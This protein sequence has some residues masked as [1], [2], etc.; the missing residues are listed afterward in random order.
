MRLDLRNFAKFAALGVTGYMGGQIRADQERQQEQEQQFNRALQMFQLQRGMEDDDARRADQADQ[1]LLSIL[2]NVHPSAQGAVMERV[3]GGRAA[4]AGAPRTGLDSVLP[5]VPRGKEYDG[6]RDYFGKIAGRNAAP[7]APT[8]TGQMLNGAAA[9]GGRSVN[10]PGFGALPLRDPA[11]E[12]AYG[13]AIQ[14]YEG[15]LD[16]NAKTPIRD[17]AQRQKLEAALGQLRGGSAQ[18]APLEG[19]GYGPAGLSLLAPPGVNPKDSE[20]SMKAIEETLAA[21]DRVARDLPNDEWGTKTRQTIATL[22]GNAPRTLPQSPDEL[23]ASDRWRD[24]AGLYTLNPS[25]GRE[26]LEER[27]L[28]DDSVGY[29]DRIN[30]LDTL[31]DENLGVELSELIGMEDGLRKRYGARKALA[32]RLGTHRED[33]A[34]IKAALD[35]GDKATA[36][37]LAGTLRGRITRRFTPAQERTKLSEVMQ[38][39][40]RMSDTARTPENMR[41]LFKNAGV[42]Y[43]V[44]DLPDGALSFGGQAAD[45]AYQQMIGK[46]PGFAKLDKSSQGLLLDEIAGLAKATGRQVEIP[47]AIVNNDPVAAKRLALLDKQITLAGDRIERD[48]ARWNLDKQIRQKELDNLKAGGTKSGKG[49]AGVEK[50]GPQQTKTAQALQH[51]AD[52]AAKEYFAIVGASRGKLNPQ[53]F[54]VETL[55][56]GAPE[57]IAKQPPEVQQAIRKYSAWKAKEKKNMDFLSQWKPTGS[58]AAPTQKGRDIIL[59]KSK[60]RKVNLGALSEDDVTAAFRKSDPTMT[61]AEAREKARRALQQAR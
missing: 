1:G 35:K 18:G 31:D 37:E 6:F 60:E 15:A 29:Y 56:K 21:L 36:A 3:L 48:K 46:L 61:E 49:G 59:N 25:L 39:V 8:G 22:K 2:P 43:L 33:I 53:D 11:S 55:A 26:S 54:D 44:R 20:R 58:S 10:V 47:A 32:P 57:Q 50:W 27:Q 9:P 52:S 23:Q 13:H 14:Q 42:D 12:A 24:L 4:R 28:R 17:P 51:E 5:M 16:P 45:K 30:G 7:S 34:A 41:T 38:I 40:G 19:L